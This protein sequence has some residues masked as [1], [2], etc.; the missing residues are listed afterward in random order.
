MCAIFQVCVR[1]SVSLCVC[2]KVVAVV[3]RIVVPN[4]YITVCVCVCVFVC[5]YSVLALQ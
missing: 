1:V 5:V 3:S 2:G 4:T